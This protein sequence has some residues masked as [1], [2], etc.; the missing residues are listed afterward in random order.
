[1]RWHTRRV[2]ARAMDTAHIRLCLPTNITS[3]KIA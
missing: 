3:T 1:M 2:D